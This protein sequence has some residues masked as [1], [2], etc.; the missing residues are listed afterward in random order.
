MS[1]KERGKRNIWLRALVIVLI[2]LCLAALGG[3]YITVRHLGRGADPEKPPEP[4]PMYA[5]EP[6]YVNLAGDQGRVVLKAVITLDLRN[7]KIANNMETYDPIV[8]DEIIAFLRSKTPDELKDQ[9]RYEELKAEI[10][11]RIN[12]HLPEDS[13]DAVYFTEFL[14]SH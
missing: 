6:F 12:R 11:R 4:G 1:A 7:G 8:R 5:L 10:R 13:V 2:V 9:N 14:I 3:I